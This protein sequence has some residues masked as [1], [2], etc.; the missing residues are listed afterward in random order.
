MAEIDDLEI[1]VKIIEQLP[2]VV[3]ISL[4]RKFH[5]LSIGVAESKAVKWMKLLCCEDKRKCNYKLKLLQML[6][7][8]KC[9]FC[10]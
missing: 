7:L 4:S 9:E 8:M 10:S 6:N 2:L 1:G 5:L 3:M